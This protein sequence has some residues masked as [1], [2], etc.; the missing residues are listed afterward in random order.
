MPNSGKPN[1][2]T[3]GERN[4]NPLNIRKNP[5]VRWQGTDCPQTDAE[6]VVYESPKWGYRAACTVLR[7]Y[8]KKHHLNTVR[9]IIHR[10]APPN[11]NDSDGYAS[12][13][14]SKL[15]V[16]VDEEIDLLQWEV[17]FQLLKIMTVAENGRCIHADEVIT[18]GMVAAGMQLPQSRQPALLQPTNVA[19]IGGTVAA[20]A[21]V[22]VQTM[23]VLKDASDHALTLGG[24]ALGPAFALLALA[25]ILSLAWTA[26]R[27]GRILGH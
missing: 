6:F 15:D 3:R 8:W 2:P 17:M 27:H 26:M 4:H 5:G 11:E 25:A 23:D 13:V 14:A 24:D 19:A 16:S 9:G 7:Q 20:A 21:G 1:K 18:A 12:F 22:V 10:W